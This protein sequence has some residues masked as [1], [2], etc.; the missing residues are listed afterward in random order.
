MHEDPA[1][2]TPKSYHDGDHTH[3][4]CHGHY[5]DFLILEVSGKGENVGILQAGCQGYGCTWPEV[6]HQHKFPKNISPSQSMVVEI[7]AHNKM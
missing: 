2:P 1:H 3:L 4:G 6:L 7:L 5:P